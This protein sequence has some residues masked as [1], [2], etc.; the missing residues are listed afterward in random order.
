MVAEPIQVLR[1]AAA[2]AA[3]AARRARLVIAGATGAMG[4]EV[5]RLLVG[6]L[7]FDSTE[8]LASEPMTTGLRHVHSWVAP[9]AEPGE[10]PPLAAD[11]AVVM[12][13]PPRLFYGR[14]RALWTPA[15]QQLPALARWLRVGG[16]QTLAIVMPHTQM[17]LPQALKQGLANLD[18]QAIAALGF[19]R[20]L[21][22]RTAQKPSDRA[23]PNPLAAVAHWMLSAFKYMVPSGE[24]PVR[25]VKVA[26][27][28]ACALRMA[29]PGIHVAAPETV[30]QASQGQVRAEVARWLEVP[31]EQP[32][33]G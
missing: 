2:P 11:T 18:E 5:M 32:P 33:A 10:W 9:A 12:F 4:N 24:L 3:P 20:L 26:E 29:P 21:I 23:A 22:V 16:V 17:R 28:V 7:A 30:W 27:F 25:A 31:G 8:V 13:D 19:E 6:S 1:S 14:E 15:P